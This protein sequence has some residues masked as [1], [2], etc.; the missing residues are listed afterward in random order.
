[1]LP[2]RCWRTGLARVEAFEPPAAGARVV[3]GECKERDD[4]GELDEQR[5][6]VPRL[7]ELVDAAKLDE[8]VQEAGGGKEEDRG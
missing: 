4:Q 3:G 1:M 7:P 5:Q 2:L 8:G 6:A